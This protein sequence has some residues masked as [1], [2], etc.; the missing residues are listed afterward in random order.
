MIYWAG[1]GL[2]NNDKRLER[3]RKKARTTDCTG[4]SELKR[5]DVLMLLEGLS[6][7]HFKKSKRYK[8]A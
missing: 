2:V 8:I 6:V 7:E 5:E 3:G 1:D 4:G